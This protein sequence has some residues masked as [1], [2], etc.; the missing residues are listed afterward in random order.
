MTIRTRFR[1][2]LAVAGDPAVEHFSTPY[3]ATDFAND[4]NV[5]TTVLH[6]V[7]RGASTSAPLQSEIETFIDEMEARYEPVLHRPAS[8]EDPAAV[9]A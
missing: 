7:L 4:H 1:V 5:S 2:A 6:E 9:P 8:F 3:T